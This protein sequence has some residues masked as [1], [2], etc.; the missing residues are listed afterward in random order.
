MKASTIF[1]GEGIAR[2][3]YVR[4]QVTPNGKIFWEPSRDRHGHQ[5]GWTEAHGSLTHALR[6]LVERGYSP[7][8]DIRPVELFAD[9]IRR[10][11]GF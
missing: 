3:M 10:R 11:A 8:S 5:D 4:G 1:T 7:F 2:G 6:S 9:R